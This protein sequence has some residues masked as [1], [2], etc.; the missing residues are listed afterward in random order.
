MGTGAIRQLDAFT[1]E[2]RRFYALPKYRGTGLG[3]QINQTLIEFAR[4]TG[5]EKIVLESH[6]DMPAAVKFYEKAGFHQ[7]EPYAG[8]PLDYSN[9]A[10]AYTIK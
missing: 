4:Q 8:E 3:R 2:L 10:F 7:I 1:A 5:Y 6:T 9:I